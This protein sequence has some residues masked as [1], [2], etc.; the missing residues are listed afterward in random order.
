MLAECMSECV[1]VCLSVCIT[2][3]TKE[4]EAMIS[5]G[6]H[7]QGIDGIGKRKGKGGNDV[8]LF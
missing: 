2:I 7:G 1:C 3:A 4:K 8:V 5:R 6:N